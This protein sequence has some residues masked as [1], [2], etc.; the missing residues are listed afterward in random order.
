LVKIFGGPEA[1]LDRA[2]NW[3]KT[4]AGQI[5]VG[6]RYSGKIRRIV[7]FGLFVE[8]VPGQDGLVHVSNIPREKQRT[9]MNDYKV[10][11]VVNV[12][13]ADYDPVTG[14]IRLKIVQ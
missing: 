3:V 12:Q 4:L 13:V 6:A 5:E 11:E 7:D 2:I 8:L 10:D 1:D 9:F 14:R